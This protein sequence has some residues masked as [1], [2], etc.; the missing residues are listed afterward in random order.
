[1]IVCGRRLRAFAA[2][3]TR[4]YRTKSLLSVNEHR[5]PI[6]WITSLS[7]ILLLC[8]SASKLSAANLDPNNGST[9]STSP[10]LNR[11]LHE[12]PTWLKLL[13]VVPADGGGFHADIVNQDFYLTS[14]SPLNPATEL[15]ATIRGFSEKTENARVL[16][17]R[18]QARFFWLN[19][20]MPDRF[21][22][23]KDAACPNFDAWSDLQSISSLSVVQVS[24][25]LG[26]P[27]SAFGHL[28]LR[29]NKKTSTGQRGLQDIGVN[30][31][32]KIPDGE[33]ALQYIAKGL[34]GGYTAGFTDKEFYA[35]DH[36]YSSTEFRDMWAYQ[37]NLEQDQLEFLVYH[38]WELI[39]ARF[40]YFF[41]RKN[42]AYHLAELLE[43]VLEESFD[44]PVQ[45][46]YLPVS[47]FHQL[48]H[49][50]DQLNGELVEKV[51]FIPSLQRDAYTE[52]EQ[53]SASESA[54]A[55]R[56]I[57][58]R[59]FDTAPEQT[60]VAVLNFLL[61]YIDYKSVGA[62][63]E[64]L[65]ELKSLRQAALIRRFSLPGASAQEPIIPTT[66]ESPATGPKSRK[67]RI[68]GVS[69]SDD[70]VSTEIQIAPYAFDLLNQNKASLIDSQFKLGE[71]TFEANA[72]ELTLHQ[73]DLIRLE[74]LVPRSSRIVDEGH[75]AWRMSL[76][77]LGNPTGCIN[78]NELFFEG[79]IGQSVQLGSNL[80]AY[81]FLDGRATPTNSRA[82]ISLGSYFR[83]SSKLRFNGEA[84]WFALT[85]GQSVN[86]FRLEGLLN[87]TR[88]TDIHM[89]VRH[90]NELTRSSFGVI[91]RW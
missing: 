28:L 35:Q 3:S 34:F 70:A 21:S 26:N 42:C 67:L 20:Q 39:N 12:H 58:E 23:L 88:N 30:F 24:G 7:V 27:A 80:L 15:A 51:S 36:V 52:F 16:R 72:G 69:Q 91:L 33:S 8:I 44:L 81:G 75:R 29:V 64:L 85:S 14:R 57:L 79:G 82:G 11:N 1:M 19:K 59:S 55:N 41:L 74:K 37:L 61:A 47:L 78:C 54:I 18:F 77:F 56:I 83:V 62:S 68:S 46:W 89:A 76:G 65:T 25:Y 60:S 66:I 6:G 9:L 10:S 2:L 32:A 71:L 17:C 48:T 49:L 73:F 22:H 53:L 13:H 90:K 63:D 86:E 38:L 84:S 4:R 5:R 87:I 50:D 43:L 31:G 40:D 45:P